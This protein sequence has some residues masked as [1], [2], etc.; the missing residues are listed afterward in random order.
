[1]AVGRTIDFIGNSGLRFIKKPTDPSTAP[2]I[3]R[4]ALVE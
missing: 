1:M 4:V 3:F 2:P